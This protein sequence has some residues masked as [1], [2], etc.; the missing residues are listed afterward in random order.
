VSNLL[1]RFTGE[2]GRRAR[3][4]MLLRQ[5]AL[6]RDAVAAALLAEQVSVYAVGAGEP[7]I[8]Q[9]QTDT[10]VHFL[11]YGEVSIEVNGREITRRVAGQHVGEMA[12]ID[13]SQNRSATVRARADV[14]AAR[15]SEATF[16]A[17]ADSHPALWRGLAV[18]LASRLR[19]RIGHVRPRNESPVLFIG[20]CS[21]RE[22]LEIAR[23]FQAAFSHDP[24]ITRIWT[25]GV[26]G[27]GKTPI[28]S[29]AA[30]L[31][32]IDFGLL[33]LTADDLVKV[34]ALAAPSPRDNV[35]FELGLAIG[36][37]GR[38]RAFCVK[39]RCG[40]DDLRLP[41]D[42]LGVQPLEIRAGSGADLASRVGAAATELRHIINRLGA[43]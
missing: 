24:W 18:E 3:L 19:Q 14:V 30:Q 39:H 4:E 21:S 25:D 12:M 28:E 17:L 15:V 34:G 33:V 9:G 8:S 5:P 1:D 7:I 40:A 29:L 31:S 38:E 36:A 16:V 27:A 32:E 37:L 20:S 35:L 22:G 6:A 2:T 13:P 42:L 11:L 26:F 41:S 43:R 10:D 23:A